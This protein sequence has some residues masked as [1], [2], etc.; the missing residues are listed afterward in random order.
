MRQQPPDAV[1]FA[2]WPAEAKRALQNHNIGAIPSQI[3][4]YSV[5]GSVL[6]FFLL[7]HFVS[8][9]FLLIKLCVFVYIFCI[10]SVLSALTGAL[11]IMVPY[12]SFWTPFLLL[13]IFSID[14]NRHIFFFEVAMTL[15]EYH[16]EYII[17]I[18]L[19]IPFVCFLCCCCYWF[20]FVVIDLSGGGKQLLP[21]WTKSLLHP[22]PGA[23]VH[24]RGVGGC[25]RS[26]NRDKFLEIPSKF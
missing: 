5:I 11:C 16:Q 13:Q 4:F 8:S 25:W 26:R 14:A 6:L 10:D 22:F 7:L 12:Y 21:E 20:H 17:T 18:L 9:L 23:I 19:L 3:S 24:R 15:I 1:Y 2:I